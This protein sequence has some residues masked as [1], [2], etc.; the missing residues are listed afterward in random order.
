MVDG[1][2]MPVSLEKRVS[3]SGLRIVWVQSEIACFTV[4][5][6]LVPNAIVAT[7][8]CVIGLCHAFGKTGGVSRDRPDTRQIVVRVNIRRRWNVETGWYMTVFNYRVMPY[9]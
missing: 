5:S 7:Y 6:E 2:E 9:D 3:D 8:Q 4:D 1:T